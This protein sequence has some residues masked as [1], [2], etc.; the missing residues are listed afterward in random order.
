MKRLTSIFAVSCVAVSAFGFLVHGQGLKI[1]D[2]LPTFD[3]PNV[4]GKKVFSTDLQNPGH[5]AFIYFINDMDNTSRET[6]AYFN[7]LVRMYQPGNV[8]VFGITNARQE[9]ARSWQSE[10]KPPYQV[11]TDP[12]L[13]SMKLMAIKSAP[14]IVMINPDGKVGRIWSGFS[15]PMLK[16]VNAAMAGSVSRRAQVFDLGTAPATTRYG[17]PYIEQGNTTGG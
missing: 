15:A 9:Q 8:K 4:D 16:E 3:L 14:T 11:L 13:A 2:A 5:P 17:R 12:Q 10:F 6:T 1:G 7:R